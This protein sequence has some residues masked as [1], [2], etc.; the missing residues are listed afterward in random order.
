[1]TIHAWRIVKA[2]HSATAFTGDGAKKHGGRWNAPGVA[3]IYTAGSASLAI[4]EMLVHLQTQE[5]LRHY[6][7]FEVTFDDAWVT[8]VDVT[9]L[10]K[11]WRQSPPPASIQQIGTVWVAGGE[12]AVLR[13]PCSIVPTEWNYLLNP[14]HPDSAKITVGSKQPVQFDPRLFKTSAPVHSPSL[15]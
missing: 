2:R 6:A 8:A 12:S 10:P 13:V 7:I 1:M 11:T 5:L 14:A 9:A 4:L 15:Q 3:M